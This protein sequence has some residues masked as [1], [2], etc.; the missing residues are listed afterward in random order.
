MA[1]REVWDPD[2]YERNAR[3]VT[4]LGE[5]V[6]A[7]LDPKPDERILD[8]GC[9]D[10]VL[11]AK[12]AAQGRRVIGI[13]GS[14]AFVAAACARGLDARVG[15]GQAL[16]FESEFD[17]VFSNAAPVLCDAQGCWHADSVRLRFA[18]MKPA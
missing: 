14:P 11:T 3:F 5:P 2:R 10:G 12:L 17:A 4:D 13:D 9:G 6:V 15:D 16:A 7:L 1:D 8:L 18:A